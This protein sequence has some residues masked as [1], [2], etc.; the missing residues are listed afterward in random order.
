[1]TD[2]LGTGESAR[3][4]THCQGEVE[5]FG[6]E[7]EGTVPPSHGR[8]F[9]GGAGPP[10]PHGGELE[11]GGLPPLF[12]GVWSGRSGT[13]S[14]ARDLN[15]ATSARWIRGGQH[16]KSACVKGLSG[17]RSMTSFV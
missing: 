6:K 3:I 1:M 13:N 5:G 7:E 12:R 8:V 15:R 16:D 17:S 9:E 10:F 11:R 2:S 4:V 14:C